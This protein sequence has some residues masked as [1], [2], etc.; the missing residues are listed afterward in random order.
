MP[1]IEL[2][3][4]HDD[5]CRQGVSDEAAPYEDA[6]FLCDEAGVQRCGD[7]GVTQGVEQWTR[8]ILSLELFWKQQYSLQSAFV[9]V[10]YNVVYK[11][12]N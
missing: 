9:A 6:F 3:L 7:G 8:N 11:P 10:H 2:E 4:L 12:T 5:S 1:P